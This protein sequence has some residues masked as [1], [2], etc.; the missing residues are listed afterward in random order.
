MKLYDIPKGSKI[1]IISDADTPP[2][3]PK[4]NQEDILIFDHLD[5]MYS[6]CINLKGEIVHLAGWTEVEIVK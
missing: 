3:S 6:Y 5:G 1:R 2:E 4:L